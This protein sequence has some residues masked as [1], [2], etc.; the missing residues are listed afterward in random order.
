[1]NNIKATNE[2][3]KPVH[4]KKKIVIPDLISLPPYLIRGNPVFKDLHDIVR[5]KC[6]ES[7]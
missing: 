6:L 1:M 5:R 3:L 4:D 7:L 2:M